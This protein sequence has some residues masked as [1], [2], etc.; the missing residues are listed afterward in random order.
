MKYFKSD[1]EFNLYLDRLNSLLKYDFEWQYTQ[2][3]KDHK[4][5]FDVEIK[6][7]ENYFKR[8]YGASYDAVLKLSRLSMERLLYAVFA[9]N[10]NLEYLSDK[11]IRKQA[12]D[13]RKALN[14][15]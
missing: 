11:L 2:A 12:E 4:D 9:G 6:E 15:M 10:C 14:G 1:K 8:P 13:I 3:R 5:M 7:G